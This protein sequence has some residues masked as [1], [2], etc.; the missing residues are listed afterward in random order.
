[1][2]REYW[3]ER[4]SYR[5]VFQTIE[6]GPGYWGTQFP[7]PQMKYRVNVVTDFIP[8]KPVLGWNWGGTSTLNDQAGIA[9]ISNSLL[10]APDGIF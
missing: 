3:P 5:D 10:Y 4:A 9:Q 6:G 1:M 8:P 7:D 2:A